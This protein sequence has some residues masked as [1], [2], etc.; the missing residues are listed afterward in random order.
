MNDRWPFAGSRTT[1]RDH[2]ADQTAHRSDG[3]GNK[4]HERIDAGKEAHSNPF[5]LVQ[6]KGEELPLSRSLS[7]SNRTRT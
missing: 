5:S 6:L 7:I 2:E 3:N 4:E 1:Q